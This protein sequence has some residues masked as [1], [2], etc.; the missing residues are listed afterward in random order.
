MTC[1]CFQPLDHLAQ[2]RLEILH[3]D[4]TLVAVEKFDKTRHVRALEVVRQADIHVED[5]NGV[6]HAAVLVLHLDRM[7]D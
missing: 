4:F 3:G 7:A 5:G 1:F 6:L 2:R